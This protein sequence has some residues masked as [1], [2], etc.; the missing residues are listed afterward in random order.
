M[1]DKDRRQSSH[2]S[3]R[4][5]TA[6]TFWRDP[7]DDHELQNGLRHLRR[8]DCVH[9]RHADMFDLG[10]SHQVIVHKLLTGRKGRFHTNSHH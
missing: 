5:P 8:D 3:Y 10:V 9:C 7:F 6:I 2:E 1:D 4:P